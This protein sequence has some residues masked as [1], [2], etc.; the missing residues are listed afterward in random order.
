[1]R[2]R[3]ITLAALAAFVLGPAP[4]HAH[5]AFG[6]LGPF[7]ARFLHP[8]A[9]PL[10]AALIVG[11]GAFLAGRSLDAVRAA[12]PLFALSAMLAAVLGQ[13]FG[14]ALWH[15]GGVPP[16]VPV[17]AALAAGVAAMLPARRVP[18]SAG[19]ALMAATGALAGLSPGAP[20]GT[21]PLQ[22]LAGTILGIAVLATLLWFALEAAGTRLT[23]F[24]PQVAG[25]WVAA[26]AILVAAVSL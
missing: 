23:P 4:A 3:A 8:L 7:Y 2:G 21:A 26:V 10:Q 24:V 17:L 22:A 16:S 11:A 1:M 5:D 25:S 9:D 13:V 6:D 18:H 15:A 19:F 12:L 14:P 20:A